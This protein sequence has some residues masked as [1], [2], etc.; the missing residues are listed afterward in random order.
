[1]KW[2]RKNLWVIYLCSV[3]VV[4]GLC[5]LLVRWVNQNAETPSQ[6]IASVCSDNYSNADDIRQCEIR[7]SYRVLLE[8]RA[9]RQA[10]VDR[11]VGN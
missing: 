1:M 8:R 5:V 11:Q 2:L 4:G 7:E 10:D 3:F 9:S 6:H